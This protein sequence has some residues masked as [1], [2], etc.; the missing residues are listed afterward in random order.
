PVL[1]AGLTGYLAIL[2]SST[3][4]EIPAK[5]NASNTSV[6]IPLDY[7]NASGTYSLCVRAFNDISTGP[8]SDPADPIG[9]GFCLSANKDKAA[10]VLPMSGSLPQAPFEMVCYLPELYKTA[11]QTLPSSDPFILSALTGTGSFKYKITFAPDSMVWNF[12]SSPVRTSLLDSYQKFLLSLEGKA[13]NQDPTTIGILL[14][15]AIQDVVDTI[16]GMMPQTF[17][18]TLY[19]HY[20]LLTQNNYTDLRPGMRLRL[21]YQQWQSVSSQP[22]QYI[23]GYV[24]NNIAEYD[25]GSYLNGSGNTSVGFN[26][27]L[28]SLSNLAVPTPAASG[29]GPVDGGGGVIDLFFR[30]F[31]RPFYRIIYPSTFKSS[32]NQ[33]SSNPKDN[34]LILAAAD[35]FTL[36]DITQKITNGASIPAIGTNY[37][38][39]YMRGR[40]AMTPLICISVNG[41]SIWVP[42]GTTLSQVLEQYGIKPFS[43]PASVGGLRY[44]RKSGNMYANISEQAPKFITGLSLPVH[45]EWGNSVIYSNS[46]GWFNLPV[47]QGDQITFT[48]E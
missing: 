44:I 17:A 4:Q 35:W 41:T 6:C 13:P 21:E 45:F 16:A 2:T 47:L 29:S 26:N 36:S 3:T 30:E 22:P 24:G 8:C 32:S 5:V 19:Y 12:D 33:G 14:P 9:A 40:A 11:P 18:E 10:A 15:G 7:S 38:I 25:I 1:S 34:A 20:G 28:S 42:V 27:F 39:L 31:Q 43:L 46:S 23:N 37:A 48:G